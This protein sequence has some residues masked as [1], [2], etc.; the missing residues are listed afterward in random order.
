MSHSLRALLAKALAATV[1]WTLFQSGAACQS[2]SRPDRTEPMANFRMR[3][4]KSVQLLVQRGQRCERYFSY[5]EAID[6]YS[7][8][9]ALL[10]KDTKLL[11]LRADAYCVNLQYAAALADYNKAIALCNHDTKDSSSL[12]DFYRERATVYFK[13]KKLKESVAD[14]TMAIKF[15]SPNAGALLD[16]ERVYE[17]LGDTAGAIADCKSALPFADSHTAGVYNRLGN[18][19]LKTKRYKEAV[20]AFSHQIQL[21]SD[22]SEGY[23]GRAKAYEYLGEKAKAAADTKKGHDLDMTY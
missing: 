11:K 16:R 15:H 9:I 23:N 7:K 21:Q 19:Y 6:A 13:T 3:Y 14:D 12:S 2:G 18:L 5:S 1:T 22:L 8:A 17:E 4:P 20:D 10:P